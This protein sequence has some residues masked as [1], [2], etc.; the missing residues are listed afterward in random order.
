MHAGLQHTKMILM[1][2]SEGATGGVMRTARP[3]AHCGHVTL[4]RS[5]VGSVIMSS[6]TLASWSL[7]D[8]GRRQGV[9]K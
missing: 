9:S 6:G 8:E 4:L 5:S 1:R 2:L 3:L 7:Q